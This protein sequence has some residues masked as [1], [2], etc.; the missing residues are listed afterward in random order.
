MQMHGTVPQ[1]NPGAAGGG[2][3][4]ENAKDVIDG[5]TNT[6]RRQ[7]LQIKKAGNGGSVWARHDGHAIAAK[8]GG[9]RFKGGWKVTCPC[10]EDRKP[11]LVL[12]DDGLLT[13]FAKCD[14]FAVSKTLSELGFP[15]IGQARPLSAAEVAK[16]QQEA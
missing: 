7:S 15:I 6:K 11:S 9:K 14:G 13:C 8:R 4:I 12:R 1:D 3:G 5:G 16:S 10:H 2:T